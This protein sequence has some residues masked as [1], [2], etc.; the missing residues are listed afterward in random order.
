MTSAKKTIK[1]LK[2][3][4]KYYLKICAVSKNG[5]NIGKWSGVISAKTK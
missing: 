2:K 4:K 3:S 5:K 1:K